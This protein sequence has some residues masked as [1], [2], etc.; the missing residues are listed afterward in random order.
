M[1]HQLKISFNL[2]TSR[3]NNKGESPIFCKLSFQNTY[4]TFSTGFYI[5][6]ELWDRESQR[7][8]GIA[9]QA[10]LTNTKLQEVNLQFIRIEKQLY[11]EGKDITLAEVYSRYLGKTDEKLLC[12]VFEERTAAWRAL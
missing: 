10:Q 3:R 8:K 2:I 11:D 7:M 5:T 4:K 9:D 6:P 12:M 1:V